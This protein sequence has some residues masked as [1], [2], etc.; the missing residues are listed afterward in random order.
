MKQF[1][2]Y[3]IFIALS[4][5][6]IAFFGYNFY[7]YNIINKE[8]SRISDNLK[9]VDNIRFYER[10][11]R[12]LELE[13]ENVS[14]QSFTSKS[15][16]EFIA[17]LPKLGD[18]SGLDHIKIES[19]GVST[20]NDL[21]I[22]VLKVTASSLFPQIANFIDFLERSKLPIQISSLEMKFVKN[23]LQTQMMLRIYKKNIED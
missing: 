22:T 3:I 14:R 2:F 7:H 20:E 13:F 5:A 1:N 10:T 11:V 4:L 17:T 12:S 18:L 23:Q 16:S 19:Q 15:T 8:L 9:D 6:W 21:E